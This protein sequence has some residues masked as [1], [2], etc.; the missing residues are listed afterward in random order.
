FTQ[1]EIQQIEQEQDTS[2]RLVVRAPFDGTIVERDAVVGEAVDTGE[3]VFTVADLSS[4]WLM[5]SIPSRHITQ[6]QRGQVVTARFEE[7]P[8]VDIRGT[9]T[10]IDSAIDPQSR[11]IKARALVT[12]DAD[13]IK[14]GLFGRAQVV[15]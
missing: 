3:P 15:I 7:L 9:I 4:R 5:L 1:G 12:E 13:R 6:I 8:G 10:W 11:M 14:T 2:A